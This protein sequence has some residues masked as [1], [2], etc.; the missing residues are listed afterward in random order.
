MT[1]TAAPQAASAV[2]E[3]PATGSARRPLPS[4]TAHALGGGVAV[5]WLGG[6]A[7]GGGRGRAR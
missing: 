3:G 6:G 7:R 1:Y 5:A 2:G 4:V